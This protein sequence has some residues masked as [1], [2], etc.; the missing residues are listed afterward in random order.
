MWLHELQK[1]HMMI[2]KHRYCNAAVTEGEEE[3]KFYIGAEVH[4]RGAPRC[5]VGAGAAAMKFRGRT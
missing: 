4:G 2:G 3:D 5:K 1:M